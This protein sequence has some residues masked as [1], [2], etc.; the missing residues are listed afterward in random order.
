[1]S[2]CL[3]LRAI[4]VPDPEPDLLRVGRLKPAPTA[5]CISLGAN[6]SSAAIYPHTSTYTTNSTQ[7]GLRQ[8]SEAVEIY[9][10]GYTGSQEKE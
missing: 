4:L 3:R 9:S 5:G 10:F 8:V 6:L 7:N 1:M 2:Q